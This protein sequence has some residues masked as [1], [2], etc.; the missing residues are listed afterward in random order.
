MLFHTAA[1]A[2][3]VGILLDRASAIRL[4][5][6]RGAASVVGLSYEKQYASSQ[7]ANKDAPSDVADLSMQNQ[8]RF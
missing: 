5:Q 8:V 6:P 3:A 4:V 7:Y 2:A 1:T